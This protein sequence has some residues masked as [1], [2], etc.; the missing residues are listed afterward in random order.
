MK[1]AIRII[2]G[3]DLELIINN[4]LL[5]KIKLDTIIHLIEN[6]IEYNRVPDRK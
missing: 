6:I 1:I 3:K 5:D 2:N 4:K